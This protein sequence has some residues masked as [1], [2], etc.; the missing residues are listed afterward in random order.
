MQ[1]ETLK[2]ACNFLKIDQKVYRASTP[3]PKDMSKEITEDMQFFR[4]ELVKHILKI[5]WFEKVFILVDTNVLQV[6]F[7]F[8]RLQKSLI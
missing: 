1:E 5:E 4:K 6:R 8:Y 2:L 7:D 3:G